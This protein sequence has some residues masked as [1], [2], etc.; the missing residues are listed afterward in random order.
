MKNGLKNRGVLDS[1]TDADPIV[2]KHQ[3]RRQICSKEIVTPHNT[4]LSIIDNLLVFMISL[5]FVFPFPSF[6]LNKAM[7]LGL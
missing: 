7:T 3:R 6:V 1:S 4:Q 5:F 2:S